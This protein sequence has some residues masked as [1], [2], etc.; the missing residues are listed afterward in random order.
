MFFVVRN[1]KCH[2]SS[3]SWVRLSKASMG[4]ES[5]GAVLCIQRTLFH[6]ATPF[7]LPGDAIILV[8]GPASMYRIREI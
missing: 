5:E 4:V 6:D 3:Y 7:L 2:G 8:P 1:S